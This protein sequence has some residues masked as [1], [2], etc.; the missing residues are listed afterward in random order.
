[1]NVKELKKYELIVKA[2][3]LDVADESLMGFMAE[4]AAVDFQTA[5]EMWEYLLTVHG[6]RM[7]D[8]VVSYNAEAKVFEALQ[9][10]SDTKLRQLLACN[11]T[12]LKLI[13]TT[14][15][16]GGTA[17]N[18]SYLT[19]LILGSKIDVADEILKLLLSNKNAN[20]DFGDRMKLVVDDVFN[21]YCAKNNVR[22]PNLNRKQIMLLLE[23]VLKVKGANKALLTQRIKELG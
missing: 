12:I 9:K 2:G 5:F 14:C 22:V 11:P 1:M 18:L 21:T 13:Y 23:H 15:A 10:V 16:T 17:S 3:S 20:M 19:S 6:S 8:V 7:S 4:L